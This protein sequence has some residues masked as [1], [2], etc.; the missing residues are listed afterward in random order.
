MTI[1]PDVTPLNEAYTPKGKMGRYISTIGIFK[2]KISHCKQSNRVLLTRQ[3]RVAPAD[4][5]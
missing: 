2:L 5:Y 1:M 3:I 4:M